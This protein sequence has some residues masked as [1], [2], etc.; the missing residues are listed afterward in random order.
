L[1]TKKLHVCC[2]LGEFILT[3]MGGWKYIL[4]W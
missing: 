2:L 1:Q 4:V 3:F